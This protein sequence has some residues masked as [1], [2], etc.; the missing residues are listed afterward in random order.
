MLYTRHNHNYFIA[1]KGNTALFTTN[2]RIIRRLAPV[3]G[4]MVIEV[5][6]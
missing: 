3:V 6:W 1:T 4:L 2:S 5:E